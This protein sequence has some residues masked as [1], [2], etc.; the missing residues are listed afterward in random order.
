RKTVP[1][2]ALGDLRPLMKTRMNE[3]FHLDAVE[4][5]LE[6]PALL[7]PQEGIDVTAWVGG[8]ERPEFVRQSTLLANIWSGFECHADVV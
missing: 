1:I 6:S 2:S 7:E 8:A 3:T 5:R 4:A